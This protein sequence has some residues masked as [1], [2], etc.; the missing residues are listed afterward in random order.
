VRT[1][2]GRAR[3]YLS[4][5]YRALDNSD[6]L[7]ACLPPLLDMGVE[8]MSCEVTDRKLYL[9]VV[10]QKIKRDLPTGWS[11]TNRGHTRFDTVSPAVVISNSE[12]G[13]GALAVQ[14]SVWTGGCSNLMI[15]KEQ[16]V[17]KYHVGSKL[18]LGEETHRMLSETTKK[19]KDAALWSEMRDVVQGAFDEAQFNSQVDRLR[20]AT[21][22][23]IE[24]DVPKV[25]ELTAKKFGFTDGER[26]QILRH[27]IAGGD[28]TKY[29]LHSA[30]TRMAQ[31]VESYDRSTQI[32]AIGSNV[33]ELP[34]HEWKVLAE[35][36]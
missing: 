1:L 18:E 29:G 15:I 22:A 31:D 26:G 36:A 6:L 12:V 3:A 33:I 10:D 14:G 28:L 34:K 23:K 17:R 11:P 8:V 4:D 30:V 16:S 32:E 5:R 9:K 2:D 19:L 24:G 25:V 27:L 35:A 13:W 20:A 21:E 7:E